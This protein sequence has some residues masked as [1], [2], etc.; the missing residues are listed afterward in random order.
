MHYQ[1]MGNAVPAFIE[2]DVK[3]LDLDQVGTVVVR[4][5]HRWAQRHTKIA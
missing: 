1:A 4:V 3:G 2:V 5:R